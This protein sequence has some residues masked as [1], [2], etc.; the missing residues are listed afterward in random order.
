[1]AGYSSHTLEKHWQ[2]IDELDRI[3]LSFWVRW[4]DFGKRFELW[5]SEIYAA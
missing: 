4:V 3:K 5:C 2:K 1:M